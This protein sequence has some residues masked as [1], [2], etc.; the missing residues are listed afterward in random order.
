MH[1]FQFGGKLLTFE[2]CPPEAGSQ[3]LVYISQVVSE[4]ELVE[5]AAQLDSVLGSSLSNDPNA[6]EQLAEYCRQR[7]DA[8]SDQSERYTWFF[9]R[10]NFLPSFRTE[11]LNLLGFKQ[12]DIP[13]KFKNSVS[14]G[15][16]AQP[17]LAA[18]SRDA[19]T[20]IERKLANVDIGGPTV[21]NVV[22]PNGEDPTSMICRA[23]VC[24]NL[25]EAVELCLEAKR[26]ADALVIA[27]L[28]SQ[29]L[30]YRV[31]KYHLRQSG[32]DP[33]SLVAGSLLQSRWDTFVQAAAPSS[34]RHTLAALVTH[35]D[36]DTLAHCCEMLGD[37]LSSES[38]SSLQEAASICYLCSMS[39]DR[40]VS[41]WARVG[42]D[43][44]SLAALT[45]RALL[46]RRAAAARGRHLQ[47]GSKLDAVL[48]EYAYRLA[49]QGCLQ[50]ALNSLE[51]SA[52][53]ELRQRLATALGLLQE[54]RQQPQ[55]SQFNRNRTFSAQSNKRGSVPHTDN[56][57]NTM[58]KP[59]EQKPWQQSSVPA[60]S[61]FP[62]QNSFTSP[63]QPLQSQP[64]QPQ[65][66][67]PQPL[68]PQP[69]QPQPLQPP[70]RPGSVGPQSGGL[71]SRSKYKVDPSVASA[72]LY[73][74]YNF[75]NQSQSYGYNSPL[76]DQYKLVGYFLIL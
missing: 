57:Y 10:A 60:A 14:A 26:V 65:P 71:T 41:R 69:L 49:A 37:K 6:S 2:K 34:W 7:G 46:A 22:I 61:T 52:H 54:Q 23:L 40:L 18:L 58:P 29:D 21:S 48:N 70:P 66:L 47:E 51:G 20:L 45:E 56:T 28:G 50:S 17:D 11:V 67:Q 72:P 30:L 39:A 42:R 9:L 75:N 53:S 59:Y 25:E 32:K 5:R 62:P 38:D 27:S 64:L 13:S 76:P 36:A 8:T 4:P 24:G 19:H 15:D 43:A 55:V 12:D 68:Q 73:N 35:T 1:P 44:A 63:L 16:H 33:V 74:Q 3:R 31:Q